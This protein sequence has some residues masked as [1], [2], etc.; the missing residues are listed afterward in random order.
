LLDRGLLVGVESE[1][2]DEQR[3]DLDEVAIGALECV[4][5]A[6]PGLGGSDAAEGERAARAVIERAPYR[7]TG[8]RL[9]ME[10][11]TQRGNVAEALRVYE[12]CRA[13]LSEELG[14]TPGPELRDVHQRLL[15]QRE[16]EP[17]EEREDDR[18][19]PAL[20]TPD[21]YVGRE[22]GRERLE[23]LWNV[24]RSGHRGIALITGEPGIGKTRLCAHVAAGA[25]RSGA[26]VLY[27][28]CEEE[29]GVAYQPWVEALGVA[30]ASA[31]GDEL[32]AH[33]AEHGGDL[34]R[35]APGL[36]RRVS[37][38]PA[39][40]ESDPETERYVLF[41]AVAGFLSRI[42]RERPVLLVLDDLHAADRPTLLLL[43]HLA[44]TGAGMRMLV[45]GCYRSSDVERGGALQQTLTD[46][47]RH[48]EVER[49]E[50]TGLKET[51]VASMMEATAGRDLAAPR[52][53]TR[54]GDLARDG[55]KSVL[56]GR[57]GPPPARVGR[58]RRPS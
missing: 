2:L 49:V 19:A 4:A 51:E 34:A 3:R 37:G 50:L 25:Q 9:L 23:G 44:A 33:I 17:A 16:P 39:P 26:L 58:R 43:R 8:Y 55:R 21:P 27:G 35:L 56:R 53:G 12:Q 57:A 1:W 24:A 15:S 47:Y 11:L 28:R 13:F 6:G 22:Q 36:G 42:S 7:E 14:A 40:H 30:V 54:C 29:L 45:V 52:A 41:G 18:L 32:R 48:A 20:Q 31:P 5:A 10:A 46:L 38:L